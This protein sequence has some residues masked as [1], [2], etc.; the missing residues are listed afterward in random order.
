MKVQYDFSVKDC[1]KNLGLD[2]GGVVQQVVTNEV[3]KLSEPYVPFAEGDL[4][5]SARIENG[6]D[7]V[8]GTADPYSYAHY[9]WAGI[10]YEDPILHC[11]G[12]PVADGGWRSR[13]EKKGAPKKIPT[14]RK[15]EYQNGS[16]RGSK[17]V[18]RMLQDGGAK[19]IEDEARRTVRK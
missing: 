12:F 8:W 2:E 18:P 1:I 9:M 4:A 3:I 19:K 7:V 6:T 11:A 16:M 10:V 17:W 5:A 15:L 14:N 13:S